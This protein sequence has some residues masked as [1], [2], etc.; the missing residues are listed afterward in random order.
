MKC[1]INKKHGKLYLYLGKPGDDVGWKCKACN[2][3]YWD[4]TEQEKSIWNNGYEWGFDTNA[5]ARNE[6]KRYREIRELLGIKG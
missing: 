1:P 5:Q 6:A 4:L 2:S 3:G